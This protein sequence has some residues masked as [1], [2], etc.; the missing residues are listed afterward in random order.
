MAILNPLYHMMK[1]MR[2]RINSRIAPR[3]L[4]GTIHGEPNPRPPIDTFQ[5]DTPKES[6]DT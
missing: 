5:T 1:L 6:I 3:R 2:M 4:V